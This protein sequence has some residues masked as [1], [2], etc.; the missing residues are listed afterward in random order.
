MAYTVRRMRLRVCLTDDALFL[1]RYYANQQ[2]TEK[3]D[4]YSF[5]IVLLE[6]ISGRKPITEDYGIDWNIV[7]W[8]RLFLVIKLLV[9]FSSHSY[10]YIIHSNSFSLQSQKKEI[11]HL[12]ILI[13]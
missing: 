8:V 9:L 7:H 12:H 13:V 2:L 1:Y 4:V 3:S 6:L 5:G 10:F 11:R